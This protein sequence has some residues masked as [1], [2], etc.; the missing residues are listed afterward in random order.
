MLTGSDWPVSLMSRVESAKLTHSVISAVDLSSNGIFL[1][2]VIRMMT[3][4]G[5]NSLTALFDGG[6][7]GAFS[8]YCELSELVSGLV[9]FLATLAHDVGFF[10]SSCVD[11]PVLSSSTLQVS[12]S[13]LS[14]WA[15]MLSRRVWTI[16]RSLIMTFRIPNVSAEMSTLPSGFRE[17]VMVSHSCSMPVGGRGGELAFIILLGS[18]SLL[19]ASDAL[20]PRDKLPGSRGWC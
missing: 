11:L 12:S 8:L 14:S 15:A 17:R 13:T 10:G 1:V 9:P 5:L 3:C 2:L 7:F 4:A 6:G 20:F 16:R 19:D 18:S